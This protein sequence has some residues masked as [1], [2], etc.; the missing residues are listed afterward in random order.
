MNDWS[1]KQL[2]K[3]HEVSFTIFVVV[4]C[5]KTQRIIS[6][7]NGITTIQSCLPLLNTAR[8]PMILQSNFLTLSLLLL[9]HGWSCSGFM[10]YSSS[11]S[12]P[13]KHR[14]S[15]KQ[16]VC[17]TPRDVAI[18]TLIETIEHGK[19]PIDTLSHMLAS[20]KVKFDQKARNSAKNLVCT[21]IRREG[22]IN[23]IM[24]KYLKKVPRGRIKPIFE[25]CLRL[26]IC[27]LVFT[28]SPSFAVVSSVMNYFRNK[29][30]FTVPYCPLMN[31]ILRKIS[32]DRESI[33]KTSR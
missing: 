9:S 22:E 10:R 26:S 3:S 12:V 21:A 32:T 15:N 4:F 30:M 13:A 29:A 33:K 20:M 24:K 2:L 14:I 23:C 6:I 18:E 25:A 8:I 1:G 27:E 5:N 7:K 31:A 11:L 28:E 16:H 17:N 19:D